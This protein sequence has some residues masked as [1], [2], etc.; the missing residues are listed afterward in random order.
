MKLLN[1]KSPLLNSTI[2]FNLLVVLS[3]CQ[4][5]LSMSSEKLGAKQNPPPNAPVAPIAVPLVQEKTQE[6]PLSPALGQASLPSGLT[7]KTTLRVLD[8]SPLGPMFEKLSD[9]EKKLVNRLQTAARYGKNILREQTHRH[10]NKIHKL[11]VDSLSTP[12]RIEKTKA[13]LGPDRKEGSPYREWLAYSALFEEHAGPYTPSNR[14]YYLRLVTANQVRKL[15]ALFYPKLKEND[16]KA[17]EEITSLLTDPTYEVAR[18]PEDTID[19]ALT[20]GNMYEKGI[21][22]QEVKEALDKKTLALELNCRVT[23]DLTNKSLKCDKQTVN[24]PGIMGKALRSIVRQLRSIQTE[25]LYLTEL[26]NSEIEHTIKFFEEGNVEEFR[27]AQIAWVKDRDSSNVDFVMGFIESYDDFKNSIGSWESYVQFVDR[28]V[29]KKSHALANNASYF[30]KKMPYQEQ[31][32]K[33]FPTDYSPPALMAYYFQEVADMRS[34]GYNLPNFDDIRGKVGFKNIIRLDLPGERNSGLDVL[35]ESFKAF[36]PADRVESALKY[37][38]QSWQTLVLLHE[39]IGHGSGSYDHTK[40]K[41]GE[42]P[43]S[44]L[45]NL[46]SSLEE[47]RADLAALTFADDPILYNAQVGIYKDQNEAIEAKRAMYDLYLGTFLRG[48]VKERSLTEAHTRGNWLFIKKLIDAGVVAW[49]DPASASTPAKTA[50][51]VLRVKDYDKFQIMARELLGELQHLKAVRDQKGLDDLMAKDAPTEAINSDWAKAI[52]QRGEGLA[53]SAGAVQQPW[54]IRT[55]DLKR[56]PYF[57]V[58]GKPE[59]ESIAPCLIHY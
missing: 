47:Q 25:K 4:N 52:I 59:L 23:R 26:Q 12:S 57:E 36:F 54:V 20:G 29:T 21:T 50:T 45:G 28:E 56:G 33:T 51:Q 10:G 46:G 7:V 5:N 3:S 13:I 8:S 43:T 14:K 37:R 6:A 55:D 40:Y 49:E 32:K 30:E 44:A 39:I 16:S 53:Y 2:L 19:L 27:Q 17:A 41:E 58:C 42:D 22:S 1:N 34:G 15:I 31:F 11:I 24:T 18:T 35:K 38:D 9:K 48:F